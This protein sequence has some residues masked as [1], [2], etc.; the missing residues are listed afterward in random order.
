MDDSFLKKVFHRHY[1]HDGEL[2]NTTGPHVLTRSNAWLAS[3]EVVEKWDN[4]NEKEAS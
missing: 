1:T 3:E 4:M 2:G